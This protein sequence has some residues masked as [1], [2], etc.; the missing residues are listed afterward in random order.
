MKPDTLRRYAF[1]ETRLLWGGGFTAQELGNAFGLSRQ[2]AQAVVD[3]YR[4]LHPANISL[5]RSTRRQEAG[6]SF[7]AA[8]V[9]DGSGAL[10][11]YLRGQS[12][13]SHYMSEEVWSEIPF[14]DADRLTRSKVPNDTVRLLITALYRRCSVG[15][16]Y[17][18]E[19]RH[20]NRVISP[21]R[22]V[23][24]DNRYHLRAYCHADHFYGDFVL[25]RILSVHMGSTNEWVSGEG[26]DTWH[27]YETLR[28]T[29]NPAL[30]QAMRT[31]L[32]HDYHIRTDG[33][34]KIKSSSAL[35]HYVARQMTRFHTIVQQPLWIQL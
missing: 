33:I 15:V 27:S 1:I 18:S 35:S 29:I 32:A 34:Y 22:M 31:A 2:S 6:A 25:S 28:F 9:R 20:T 21:N 8:Y 24:A 12:L 23:F 4:T 16:V 17:Q 13:V 26:D 14:T 10:L 30:P 11:D 3:D 19:K 7:R 5:N